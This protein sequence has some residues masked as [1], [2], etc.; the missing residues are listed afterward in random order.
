M[1]QIGDNI[2][3]I[4]E[5]RLFVRKLRILEINGDVYRCQ[6]RRTDRILEI[7]EYETTIYDTKEE[8]R[9]VIRKKKN[10]KNFIIALV[11]LLILVSFLG[12]IAVAVLAGM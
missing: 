3:I 6:N 8:A 1:R 4:D 2:Y 7:S 12:L 5:E 11:F 10:K 9:A